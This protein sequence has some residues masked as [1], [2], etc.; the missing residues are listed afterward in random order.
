M[1]MLIVKYK[2]IREKTYINALIISKGIK[3]MMKI[4]KYV[5]I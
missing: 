4:E 3:R 1:E 5:I 2:N